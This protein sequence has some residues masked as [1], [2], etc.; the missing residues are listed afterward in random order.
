MVCDKWA[1]RIDKADP[2]Y[3]PMRWRPKS[4][5]ALST[6]TQDDIDRVGEMADRLEPMHVG[7]QTMRRRLPES[8]CARQIPVAS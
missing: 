1:G 2:V 6:W 3:E 5:L 7:K 4:S 8:R